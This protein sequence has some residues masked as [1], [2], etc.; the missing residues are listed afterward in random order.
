V[1]VWERGGGRQSAAA[2]DQAETKR[3][4]SGEAGQ[5]RQ[6]R[7][8][9][10]NTSITRVY[11]HLEERVDV[12]RDGGEGKSKEAGANPNPKRIATL[13]RHNPFVHILHNSPTC[14]CTSI[15][16][17]YYIDFE[18]QILSRQANVF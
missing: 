14:T 11:N 9:W 5:G 3:S 10:H 15:Q 16:L 17:Q 13:R 7:F 2:I 12:V 8:Y 1:G 6:R 4:E 18:R